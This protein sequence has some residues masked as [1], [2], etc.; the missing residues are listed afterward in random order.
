MYG[1]DKLTGRIYRHVI[2]WPVYYSFS[3]VFETNVLQCRNKRNENALR[4]NVLLYQ[5]N[6]ILI[7]LIKKHCQWQN[8]L[9][10]IQLNYSNV[11]RKLD[12]NKNI[13][14]GVRGNDYYLPYIY[15]L[16]F[17]FLICIFYF[18]FQQ[19]VFTNKVFNK[20]F[21]RMIQL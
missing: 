16:T 8:K 13:C 7:L 21:L 14:I 10:D 15:S 1:W 2:Q 5:F 18:F 19:T 12:S 9:I 11:V 6:N 20:Q 17:F 4:S 3:S